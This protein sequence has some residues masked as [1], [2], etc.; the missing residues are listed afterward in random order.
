MARPKRPWGDEQMDQLIGNLLRAGVALAAAVVLAGGVLYLVR[1][2]AAHPDYRVFHNQPALLRS[3][4]RIVAAVLSL[5]ARAVIQLG[6][7]LLIATPVARVAFSVVGFAVQRD[8]VYV[9]ITL[10]VLAVLVFSLAGG[11]L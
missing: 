6:L 7:L 5:R 3:P 9:V 2:G 8:R 10:I 1:H 11:H 4:A